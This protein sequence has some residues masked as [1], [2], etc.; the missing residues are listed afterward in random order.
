MDSYERAIAI[1]RELGFAV[2]TAEALIELG[3]THQAAG[4][5]DAAR[6]EWTRAL[7]IFVEL[8]HPSA[9]QLREKLRTHHRGAPS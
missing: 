9:G 3:D 8:D 7:Q 4:R 1:H 2:P 5:P 6:A